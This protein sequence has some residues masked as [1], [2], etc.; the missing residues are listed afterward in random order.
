MVR[1]AFFQPFSGASGDMALGAMVD[2]GLSPK[3]LGEGLRSL[4][5]S[6][7]K[8]EISKV[9]R[10]AFESTRLRVI[11]ESS[12]HQD[13]HHHHHHEHGHEHTH[14]HDGRGAPSRS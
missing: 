7:W 8:L 2:A 5:V 6:G 3:E 12:P 1:I 4:N 10:G 9:V 13:Q 11:L 14:Q